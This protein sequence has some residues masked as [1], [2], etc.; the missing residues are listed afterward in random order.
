MKKI[1]VI[2]GP[3]GVGKT[4]ISQLLTEKLRA[5]YLSVDEIL[6]KN[7]LDSP[8]G[9]SVEN[10]LKANEIIFKLVNNSE[11][12]FVIDGNFYYQE[13]IDDLKQKFGDQIIFF[14]I[15]SPVEKCLKRD[16]GREKSLGEASTRFVYEITTKITEGFEIDNGDLT[17]EETVGKIMEKL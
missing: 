2:R 9:I 17:A 10:F 5:E 15:I 13:Q 3:L 14:T 8:E 16:V 1:I 4:T 6:N 7:G 11:K 12:K